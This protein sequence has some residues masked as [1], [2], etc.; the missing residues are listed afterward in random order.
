MLLRRLSRGTLGPRTIQRR[1]RDL[2]H[3][4]DTR[5]IRVIDKRGRKVSKRPV[6]I[7]LDLAQL[8][9]A[10]RSELLQAA[11]N[12]DARSFFCY[13]A[14]RNSV[15]LR[16]RLAGRAYRTTRDTTKR[17][18]MVAHGLVKRGRSGA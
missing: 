8:Q 2:Y 11:V 14:P 9:G 12:H 6:L 10:S 3:G 4:I 18:V 16:Y 15:K 17:V 13:Q 7:R 1:V 5:I